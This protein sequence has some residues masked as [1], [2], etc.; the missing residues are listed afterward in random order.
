MSA[1]DKKNIA[2]AVGGVVLSSIVA[3][4]LGTVWG[5]C[6]LGVLLMIAVVL[7]GSG[8][9][10]ED[11]QTDFT[12]IFRRKGVS[13]SVS[14]PSGPEIMLSFR[15][16]PDEDDGHLFV[17]HTGGSSARNVHLERITIGDWM[18][19]SDVVPYLP[20]GGTAKI[21]TKFIPYTPAAKAAQ[22]NGGIMLMS[23]F[24]MKSSDG[25]PNVVTVK[26][27][28]ALCQ[29]DYETDFEIVGDPHTY[30]ISCYQ[31]TRRIKP[32]PSS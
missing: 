14:V 17:Q 31:K 24:V 22:A 5:L 29:W 30:M 7:W 3:S 32:H 12:S 19:D 16:R 18:G 2:L 11:D 26:H 28:D 20:L 4:Y 15:K 13:P 10:D 8:Q 21:S 9:R 27:E 1:A 23:V 6:T 25:L